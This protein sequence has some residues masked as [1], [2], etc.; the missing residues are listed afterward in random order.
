MGAAA[1]RVAP[2]ELQGRLVVLRASGVCMCVMKGPVWLIHYTV[3][4]SRKRTGAG[5]P[6]ST[7]VAKTRGEGRGADEQG[8][9]I[10]RVLC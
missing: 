3:H 7:R 5:E 1:F 8:S 10:T 6:A 9:S 2:L 4:E